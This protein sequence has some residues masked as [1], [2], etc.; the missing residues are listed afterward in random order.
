MQPEFVRRRL[1]QRQRSNRKFNA[2][3]TGSPHSRAGMTQLDFQRGI[4]AAPACAVEISMHHP[5]GRRS[6]CDFILSALEIHALSL[7]C[8]KS[9]LTEEDPRASTGNRRKAFPA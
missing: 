4:N 9:P 6:P 8:P 2:R 7:G 3:P 5:L 1:M